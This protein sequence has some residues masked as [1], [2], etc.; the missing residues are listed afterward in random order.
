MLILMPFKKS[1]VICNY[2][3]LL[4]QF[5]INTAGFM[6]THSIYDVL[7]ALTDSSYFLA[8]SGLSP[9]EALFLYSFAL[10]FPLTHSLFS[11]L[12]LHHHSPEMRMNVKVYSHQPP[13]FGILVKLF[14]CVHFHAPF[15]SLIVLFMANLLFSQ[16]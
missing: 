4:N 10:P 13:W 1:V 15:L 3:V 6:T 16:P 9:T 7:I 14:L 2:T 8:K 5:F 11:F 12:H